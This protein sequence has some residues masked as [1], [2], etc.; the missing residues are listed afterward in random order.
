MMT[1]AAHTSESLEEM[2]R[3]LE[4]HEDYRVLRRFKP[5]A[6]ISEAALPAGARIGVIVDTETTGTSDKDKLIELG[7]VRFGYDPKTGA[8]LGAVDSYCGLEDPGM[9]I[10]PAATAVHCIT[11]EMVAGK[12]L[13]E[14]AITRLLSGARVVIAHNARF[15]RPICERRLDAFA[16]LPWGCSLKEV[17]WASAGIRGAKLEFIASCLG[18]FYSAHRADLDCQMLLHVLSQPVFEGKGGLAGLLET[19]RKPTCRVWAT[20]SPFET[21]DLLKA[22]GYQWSDGTHPDMEKAWFADVAEDALQAELEWLRSTV[23]GRAF[24]VPVDTVTAAVRHSMR[25]GQTQ[26]RRID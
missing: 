12:R 10:P 5:P 9:P 11:D 17:D 13:D 25:R 23:Y 16:H 21:K 1:Q 8:V 14:S 3:C 2:A 19:A 26:M 22:R 15:D 18:V 24:Q 7:L 6:L 20:G 4:A